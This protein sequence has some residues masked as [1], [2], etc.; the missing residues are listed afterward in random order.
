M[1]TSSARSAKIADE[2]STLW[3]TT[4]CWNDGPISTAPDAFYPEHRRGEL[5]SGVGDRDCLQD[6][7]L[8]EAAL[9]VVYRPSEEFLDGSFQFLEVGVSEH[10]V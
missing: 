3:G 5:E 10:G 6:G 9:A 2:M 7:A 1:A 8:G 4:P